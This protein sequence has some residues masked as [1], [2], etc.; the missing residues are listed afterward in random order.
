LGEEYR[1]FSY[2]V[3]PGDQNSSSIIINNNHR[4]FIYLY[5]YLFQFSAADDEALFT[6]FPLNISNAAVS[7]TGILHGTQ[8]SN[9]TV[10]WSVTCLGRFVSR[11]VLFFLFCLFLSLKWLSYRQLRAYASCVVSKYCLQPLQP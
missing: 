8:A 3:E 6:V 9:H 10:I 4:H 11:W 2:P 5:M 1:S 7:A